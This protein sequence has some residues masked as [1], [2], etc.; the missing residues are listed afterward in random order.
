MIDINYHLITASGHPPPA[1]YHVSFLKLGELGVLVV[2]VG[3][4]PGRRVHDAVQRQVNRVRVPE[5]EVRV[6]LRAADG[7]VAE[8][9]RLRWDQQPSAA[10]V[11][12]TLTR[13][14]LKVKARGHE[15][16]IDQAPG[17]LIALLG[18]TGLSTPHGP[19][20]AGSGGD[21]VREAERGEH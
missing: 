2:E 10:A 19:I 15:L 8:R 3:P 5:L 6:S 1:D 16:G 12:N 11:V 7:V 17:E 9:I 13:L 18:L 4:G 14:A 20:V 21:R